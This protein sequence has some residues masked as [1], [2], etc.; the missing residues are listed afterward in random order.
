MPRIR[1]AAAQLNVVVGDLEGNAA[2]IVK[3]FDPALDAS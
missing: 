1:V 2:R 3:A